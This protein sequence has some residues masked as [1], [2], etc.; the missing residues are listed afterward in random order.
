MPEAMR[1]SLPND[2]LSCRIQVEKGVP[3]GRDG[4]TEQRLEPLSFRK[5]LVLHFKDRDRALLGI[6]LVRVERNEP[7]AD[8]LR[9]DRTNSSKGNLLVLAKAMLSVSQKAQ[10]KSCS[11]AS[12][13]VSASMSRAAPVIRVASKG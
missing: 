12:R 2:R 9:R 6:G 7:I 3:L 4:E 11:K 5:V 13:S 8:V 10:F 1:R